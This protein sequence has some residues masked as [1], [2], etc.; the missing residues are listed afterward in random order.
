MS[1]EDTATRAPDL[2]SD[3]RAALHSLQLGIEHVYRAYADLLACHHRTGHAMDRFA[4]AERLLRSAGHEAYADDLRD[5]LLPA[6]AVDDR[7]TYEL[8]TAFRTGLVDD[9]D[10]F[11]SAVR[12][13]L[14]DGVDHVSERAQQRAW[15]ERARSRAWRESERER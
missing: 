9:L 3:E 14:A 2:D 13:D 8:V 6:G 1:S 10:A 12:A 11:E 5:R 7:W 4:D 15:R